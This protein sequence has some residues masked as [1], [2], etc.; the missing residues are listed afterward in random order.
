MPR[1]LRSIASA[2]LV[3][4]V[5][6]LAASAPPAAAM[7]RFSRPGHE[8]PLRPAERAEPGSFLALL[9]RLFDLARGTMDPNGGL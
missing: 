4:C 9:L 7:G 2:L 3:F 5:V 1:T 6:L 8:G